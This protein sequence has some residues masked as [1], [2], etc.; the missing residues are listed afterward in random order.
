MGDR[1]HAKAH[2]FTL[3]V[4]L[5]FYILIGFGVTGI[6]IFQNSS[7]YVLVMCAFHSM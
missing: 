5:M 6:C 1:L 4:K 2:E 3:R 7:N